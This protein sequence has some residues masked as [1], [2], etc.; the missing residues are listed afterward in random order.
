MTDHAGM[1]EHINRIADFV[2][3][4]INEQFGQGQEAR[5]WDK[6]PVARSLRAL[7]RVVQEIRSRTALTEQGEEPGLE[8]AVGLALTFAWGELA[9]IAHEWADHADYQDQF[10]LLAH[11]LEDAPT[12]ADTG[13]GVIS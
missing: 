12:A 6:D 9:A 13:Q 3:A 8:V 4:R 10:A 1:A 11:Q 7:R 2:E 5:H